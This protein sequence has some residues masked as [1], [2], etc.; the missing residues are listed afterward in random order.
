M[1]GPFATATEHLLPIGYPLGIGADG[2]LRVRLGDEIIVLADTL[3]I[4]LWEL[5]RSGADRAR[6]L[7]MTRSELIAHYEA[8]LH[9]RGRTRGGV[10]GDDTPAETI[11]AAIDGLVDDGLAVEL[12]GAPEQRREAAHRLRLLPL[13]QYRRYDPSSGV[14]E[15][16]LP[17]SPVVG[18]LPRDAVVWTDAERTSSL[19]DAAVVLAQL[20]A[21]DGRYAAE[22]RDPEVQLVELFQG[23]RRMLTLG[24]AYLDRAPQ[25]SP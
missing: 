21:F 20:P 8:H 14:T 10:P 18:L 1:S 19:W 23:V 13:L 17:G 4:E 5:M 3:H 6:R 15:V 24:A 12:T 16:G 9:E 22:W 2:V 11:S 25:A 7:S